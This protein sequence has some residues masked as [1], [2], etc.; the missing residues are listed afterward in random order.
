MAVDGKPVAT[1]NDLLLA[2]EENHQPGDKVMLTVVRD[3]QTIRVT[4]T[5]GEQ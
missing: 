3:G 4:V 2:V 1:Q 5:L